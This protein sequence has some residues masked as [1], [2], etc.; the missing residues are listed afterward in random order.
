MLYSKNGKAKRESV[1]RLVALTFIENPNNY[2]CVNH[3]DETRTNNNVEN[4][5]WC[6][7]K[8]NSNYGT[9]QEKHSKSRGTTIY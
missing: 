4:L 9:C 6:S 7:H 2:P 5:E 3:K 1:H 8:Y